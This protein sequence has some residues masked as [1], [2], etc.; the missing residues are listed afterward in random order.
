MKERE[1]ILVHGQYIEY[2]LMK[3]GLGINWK[4]I[5]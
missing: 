1:K 3:N 2:Y 5:D 4:N